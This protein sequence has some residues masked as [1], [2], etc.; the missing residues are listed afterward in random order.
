VDTEERWMRLA[1]DLA[2]RAEALGEVPVGAVVVADGEIAGRGFNHPIG[3]CDPT[4]HAEIAAI[5]EASRKLANYR[6][7]GATLYCTVEPCIMCLGAALHARIGRLVYGAS[8]PK[9]G[10]VAELDRLRGTGALFNHRLECQGGVLAGESSELLRRFFEKRRG[11][12]SSKSHDVENG[13]V[14]KWS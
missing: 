2:G 12:E 1:L 3:G 14:P 8:D 7:T 10:A 11:T 13:E 5:R 4:A 9:V 6:L